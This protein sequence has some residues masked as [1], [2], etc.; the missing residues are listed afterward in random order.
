MA[1]PLLYS[2]MVFD[3]IAIAALALI[4]VLA[5]LTFRDYGLGWDDYTHSQYGELLL[6]FYASG[7]HDTRALSFVNLYLYGGGFDMAAALLAKVMPFDL[8]ETRRLA[9][10]A[11]GILGLAVTWRIARRVGG[12]L[13][14]L[15]ALSLLAACP[16]YYG[17]MFIN[18][19]DAPFAVAMA[20]LLLG[21]IRTI[22]D[23]PRPAWTSVLILAF[24][25]GLSVGSRIMGGFGV[26]VAIAAVALLFAL[27][28]RAQDAR[29]AASRLGALAA[30]L[31]PAAVAAYALMALVWPWGAIDPLNP[32]RAIGIFAHFFEKPWQELFEGVLLTPPEMPRRYVPELLALQLPAILSLLGLA[33]VTGAL[34][35]AARGDRPQRCAI[36]L[37]IALAA[38]LPIVI[39]I[40][41]RPAMYNGI[42]HFIFV[43]PPLAVA[44]GLAA[45]W[46]HRRATTR[47]MRAALA[48]AL[49]IGLAVPIAQMARLHPYQYLYF[50]WI[51]GGPSGA[52]DRFMLDYWGLA[53]KQAAEA[54]RNNLAARGEMPPAARK[55]KVAVCGP[56]PGVQVALGG[57]FEPTWDPKSADF[58]LM[59]GEFYCA[60]LDAPIV[61][62]IERAGVAFARVH[63]IRGHAVPTL[64][65]IP[66]VERDAA[67]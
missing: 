54:L 13:A 64:F 1:A 33:G 41:T 31:V 53:L 5:A 15:V 19:K 61:A 8:F 32:I 47:M 38:I 58:A 39:A 46:L 36:L 49:G 63:D 26:I 40:I 52:R 6:A 7:F 3:R 17:H 44:G 29:S 28:T 67:P 24:G 65:T 25:V 62:Q 18:P 66:P 2:R 42:R 22:E 16:L 4:A 27:E 43:V 50:N 35:G 10:A 55:W 34:I 60:R 21:L 51:A 59:L 56:H 37:A 45:A 9:G 12:P 11:V 14:G 48:A 20:I 57:A 23:Y 30:R